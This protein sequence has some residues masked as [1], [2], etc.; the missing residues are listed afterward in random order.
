MNQPGSQPKRK[1]KVRLRDTPASAN[2]AGLDILSPGQVGY[3]NRPLH[4]G[5]DPVDTY[6][7][8]GRFLGL[9]IRNLFTG[10]LRTRNPILLGIMIMAGLF[11]CAFADYPALLIISGYID[12]SL[13][14]CLVP[15]GI[16]G[17]AL[18]INTALS[19]LPKSS[20]AQ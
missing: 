17:L 13:L 4:S 16:V 7:E 10:R 3:R 20:R 19:L 12:G 8:W 15:V 6:T 18:L 2:R 5:L 9:F 14:L 11:A 1:V